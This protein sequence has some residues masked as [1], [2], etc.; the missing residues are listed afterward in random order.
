MTDG[1]GVSRDHPSDRD[2]D[3]GTTIVE[4]IV[5]TMILSVGV[6]AVLTSFGSATKAS[7]AA[8]HR[9]TAAR[10]ATSEIEAVRALSHDA[11]GIATSSPGYVSRFEG[12]DTVNDGPARVEGRSEVTVG[13]T[14]YEI[15]RYVTWAPI[16]VDATRIARGYKHVTVVVGWSDAMGAHEVRLDSGVH[17]AHDG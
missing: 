8:D 2:A 3:A 9:A 12:R 5:A 16:Q 1:V 13:T 6:L 10:I 4:I 11:V 17:G 7:S 15:R 14:R